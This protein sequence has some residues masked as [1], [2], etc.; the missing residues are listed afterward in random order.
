MM[1]VLYPVH[2]AAWTLG[3]TDVPSVDVEFSQV[4]THYELFLREPM[5]IAH[6]AA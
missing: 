5:Y 4:R 3:A 2:I 6:H 1:L